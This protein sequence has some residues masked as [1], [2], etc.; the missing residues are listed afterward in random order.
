[1]RAQGREPRGAAERPTVS[2]RAAGRRGKKQGRGRRGEE[3]ADVAGPGWQREKERAG[4]VAHGLGNWAGAA[5]A[6]GKEREFGLLGP[7]LFFFFSFSFSHSTIQT[8]LFEF[9]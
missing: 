3:D 1:L 2:G 6:G 9:K 8:I 5:H 7:F 4:V